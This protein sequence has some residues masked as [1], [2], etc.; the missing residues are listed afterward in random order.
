MAIN[1]N[2]TVIIPFSRKRNIRELKKS[3]LFTKTTQ[4][5]SEVKYLGLNLNKGQTWKRQLDRVTN[6]AYRAFWTCRSTCGR[7][8]VLR[9]N[10]AYWIHTVVAR[11]LVTYA[12]TVW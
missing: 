8:S 12:A 4:L 6:K 11:I 9:L 10:V 1:P 5:S 3:T 2:K 7:T